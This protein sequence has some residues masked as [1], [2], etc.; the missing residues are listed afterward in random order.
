MRRVPLALWPLASLAA[1]AVAEVPAAADTS[2]PISGNVPTDGPNHFFLPFDVPPG[3]AEIE[4]AHDDLSKDNIL[5]WGLQGPDGVFRGW[6]GG[7]EENAI[8][9]ELAASRSYLAGPITPG[10]WRVVVGKAKVVTSPASYLVTVTLREHPTLPQQNRVP[11]APRAAI[12]LNP[13]WYAG[14]FHVHSRES[15]DARP[16]ISEVLDFA[17]SRGLDFVELS[18]H[19]TTSQ[20]DFYVENARPDVLLV[21]GVEY[22]TYAGHANGIGATKYVDDKIGQP[23]VT[24]D[25]AVDQFHAQGALFSI[26]HPALDLGDLCIGCAWKHAL[27]PEKI[28]AVEI[29]TGG[30]RQSGLVFGKKAI[31]FWDAICAT[32]RHAA[33]IGGSDDHRAGRM[34]EYNQSPIGSP[35]TMVYARELSVQGLLDG[36]RSGRTV[37]KLQD[38]TDPMIELDASGLEGDTV[39]ARGATVRAKVT[40]APMGAS[41]VFVTDGVPGDD[42]P[43]GADPFVREL[44]L[45]APASGE[46]RVRAEVWIDGAPR[47]VTSHVWIA[48]AD[49]GEDPT[50][51][52]VLGG[53]CSQGPAGSDAWTGGLATLP[54]LAVLARGRRRRLSE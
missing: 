53:G 10:T 15:G 26:N 1:L 28:D 52:G 35:T 54:L 2:F 39:R 49:R 34:L 12:R 13:G 24:I 37:V 31:A 8:V 25:G 51:R 9:G 42:I 27:S 50:Q 33:A 41:L 45:A 19:N 17:R 48:F 22:T 11:Y 43:I 46:K 32:G 30:W 40:G 36:I 47:T 21:P 23:G 14:D 16:T 6:G 5:D 44:P 20:L 3:T 18:D 29:G 4:I 7:N 38:P